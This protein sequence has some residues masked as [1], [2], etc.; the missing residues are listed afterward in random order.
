M[1]YAYMLLFYRFIKFFTFCSHCSHIK[2]LKLYRKIIINKNK[3]CVKYH[4][5]KKYENN[6]NKK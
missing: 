1:N 6:E 3:T 5:I 4:N 2:K